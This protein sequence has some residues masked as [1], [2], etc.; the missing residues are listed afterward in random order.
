M[1]RRVRMPRLR[2]PMRLPAAG[3]ASV[4]PGTCRPSNLWG[5]WVWGPTGV[6]AVLSVL[7]GCT[8]PPVSIPPP[9]PPPLPGPVRLLD[10]AVAA[11]G[12]AVIPLSEVRLACDLTRIR[13]AAAPVDPAALPPCPASLEEETV[14]QLVNRT[15]ILEDAARF[16][17]EVPAGSVEARLAALEAKLAGPEGL[18]RFLARHAIDRAALRAWLA[19][20]VLLGRYLDQ[21]IGLLVFVTPDEVE[22]FYRQN[23]EQFGGVDLPAAEPQIRAYLQRTKYRDALAEHIRSLRARADVR[24]LAVPGRAAGP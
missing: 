18:E 1:T 24:R 5:R 14:D 2:C 16:D 13:E 12:L 7:A 6:A 4:L 9:P 15:L 23:R 8:P 11:V 3:H 22:A 10:A 17:I 19:R 20:E 21:R